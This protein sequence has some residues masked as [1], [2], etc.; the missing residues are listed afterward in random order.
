MSSSSI[1]QVF[2]SS[3]VFVTEVVVDFPVG[4]QKILGLPTA[5]KSWHS[6]LF[7]QIWWKGDIFVSLFGEYLI[8]FG[9]LVQCC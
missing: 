9:F 4:A 2:S 3:Q 5:R 6:V 1:P 7:V 8:K